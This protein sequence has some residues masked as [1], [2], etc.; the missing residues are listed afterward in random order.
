MIRNYFHFLEVQNNVNSTRGNCFYLKTNQKYVGSTHQVK[1]N[2][3]DSYKSKISLT[4]QSESQHIYKQ[5][6]IFQNNVKYNSL[7]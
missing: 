1:K 4:L 3:Q 7:Q 5:N 2:N 6:K